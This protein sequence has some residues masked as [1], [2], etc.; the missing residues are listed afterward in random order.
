[1]RFPR[2]KAL[3]RPGAL[4]QVPSAGHRVG[5]PGLLGLLQLQPGQARRPLQVRARI[6]RRRRRKTQAPELLE[7]HLLLYLN[8]RALDLGSKDLLADRRVTLREGAQCFEEDLQDLLLPC[9]LRRQVHDLQSPAQTRSV[10][11]RRHGKHRVQP[12]AGKAALCARPRGREQAQPSTEP[13]RKID[14]GRGHSV[15]EPWGDY[16]VHGGLDTSEPGRGR[17][18]HRSPGRPAAADESLQT[19]PRQT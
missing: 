2:R 6:C 11:V 8:L 7:Q 14:L 12:R 9:A 5:L 3:R 4:R 15:L 10:Q 17:G 19:G 16:G 1:M 18:L 13:G